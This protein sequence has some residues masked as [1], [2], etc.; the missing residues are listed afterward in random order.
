MSVI[1][2]S[3]RGP[4]RRA[5]AYMR[6]LLAV[7]IAAAVRLMEEGAGMS[8]TSGSSALINSLQELTHDRRTVAHTGRAGAI[9]HVALRAFDVHLMNRTSTKPSSSSVHTITLY[10]CM[11][12]KSRAWLSSRL[13]ARCS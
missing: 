2:G 11:Q 5:V 7:V 3:L 10:R 12:E 6:G 9:E 1:D 4:G 13:P 8:S